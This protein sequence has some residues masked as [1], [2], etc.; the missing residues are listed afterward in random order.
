MRS[1]LLLLLGVALLCAGA[2]LLWPRSARGDEAPMQAAHWE[3]ATPEARD[4]AFA[5]WVKARFGRPVFKL[6]NGADGP[7]ADASAPG[8][9][10]A[11][12]TGSEKDLF[13]VDCHWRA[14]FDQRRVVVADAE[15]LAGYRRYEQQ[16]ACRTF[17]V[18][19]IAGTPDD[20]ADVYVVPLDRIGDGTVDMGLLVPYKQRS[21]LGTFYYYPDNSRLVLYGPPA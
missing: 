15:H 10:V 12:Q 13:A 17:I 1:F 8:L 7:H 19:G 16:N 5:Q 14:R 21:A 18:L 4:H 9:L 11:F 20:P 6:L 3:G 2:W